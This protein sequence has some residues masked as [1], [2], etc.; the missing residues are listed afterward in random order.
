MTDIVIPLC[1]G[2]RGTSARRRLLT[3]L[4]E[5]IRAAEREIGPVIV[6]LRALPVGAR[7][8]LLASPAGTLEDVR[9][10]LRRL[11]IVMV[12]RR[13]NVNSIAR[14]LST[15]LATL[16]SVNA[17]LPSILAPHD[18]PRQAVGSPQ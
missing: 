18:T 17:E 14:D 7:S 9:G 10:E 12:A 13:A 5:D 2:R 15:V 8:F 11:S 1:A 3:R 16:R 4:A 6:T